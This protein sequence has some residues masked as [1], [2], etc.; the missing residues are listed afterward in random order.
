MDFFYGQKY[1]KHFKGGKYVLLAYGYE[2]ESPDTEVVIYQALYG[3]HKVWVRPK[4]MFFDTV[5]R[6]GRTFLRFQEISREE[7]LAEE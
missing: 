7:A 2:T 4:S 1:Y 6:D 5:T 3:E